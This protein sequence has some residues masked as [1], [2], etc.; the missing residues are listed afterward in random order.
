MTEATDQLFPQAWNE[1]LAVVAEPSGKSLTFGDLEAQSNQ[2]AHLLRSVGMERGET[3][4]IVMENRAEF[5]VLAFA[6]QRSGLYYV[7]VNTHLKP[8]EAQYIITDSGAKAVLV[9]EGHAGMLDGVD[10]GVIRLVLDSAGENDRLDYSRFSTSPIADQAEGDFLLYSSGTTGRPKG[11]Q[12]ELV[13]GAFGSYPDLPGKWLTGLLGLREGD[14]YLSPA[15]LYHAAPLGWSM[16][17]LRSGASVVVM[18][19]FDP[20]H[21]LELIELH[22]VTHS[23]WVPTMLIRMLKLE[24]AVRDQFDLTS[25]RVAVHA[26]APCPIDAKRQ[27]IDWWGPILFEFYSSTEGVGATSIFSED[28]LRKPGSVGKPLLGTPYILD[29]NGQAL[30]PGEVGTIWFSGGRDFA[31]HGD[32]D[33]TA[34]AR[35][36]SNRATVG[37]IGWVDTDGFLFLSDRREH[38]I[39]SGG[40][41][42]YPQEIENL[43]VM[44]PHVGDVA[45]IGRTHPDMGERVVAVVVP[46]AG[47]ESTPDLSRTLTDYCAEHLAKYKVPS[48]FR[49]VESLPRTPTGKLRK[50]DIAM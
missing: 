23:Q 45:V 6:A 11:I 9:S 1:R 32:P 50:R 17:A 14:T 22:Q 44:H 3:V 34:S 42:I 41:N 31:Y 40:V 48:E 36:D 18:E 7:A 47:V 46:Q 49:F 15:P 27:M 4:A 37:D 24:P 13:G 39:I 2:A 28:W 33:K 20:A 35:D 12:R 10:A 8:E 5:L 38:L 26:A 19:R 29:D 30:G 21:A 43:I 25:H 16:G